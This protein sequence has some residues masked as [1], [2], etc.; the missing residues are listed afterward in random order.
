[1]GG[2]QQGAEGKRR[3]DGSVE[4]KMREAAVMAQRERGGWRRQH[5]VEEAE[6]AFY[7]VG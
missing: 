5:G 2:R 6:E 4:P 1:M 3:S 7:T